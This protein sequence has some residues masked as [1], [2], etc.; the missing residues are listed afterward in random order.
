MDDKNQV[1]LANYQDEINSAYLYEALSK[2]EKNEQLSE[3]YRKMSES[4]I[5]HAQFWKTRLED[6]GIHVEP[7]PDTRSRMLRWIAATFGIQTILPILIGGEKNASDA[8]NDKTDPQL[9]EM[10]G[11]EESHER[12]MRQMVSGTRGG[13]EGGTVAQMEGR[14][15]ASGGNALRAAVLG[16]NDGL[17]SNLSLVMGVAGAE[18]A[19]RSILIT[20]LAGLLAGAASMALGEWLSVQ[21]SR[22]LYQ[23]QIDIERAEIENAPEEEAEELSLIYQAKG[24]SEEQANHLTEKIMADKNTTVDTLAREELGINPEELGG[25]AWE[26]AITSFFLFAVGAIIPVSP[27]IFWTG[28]HAII[29]SLIFS[30]VGLFVIGALIT[31]MT[32]KNFFQSGFRQ[33]VFGLVAAGL[34]F[35]IG[36][37]IGVSIGG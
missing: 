24:L 10:A 13:M 16:A 14:H 1:S 6:A 7:K 2:L 5:K 31:L 12:L 35:G 27:F 23:H 18:L 26:A 3:V 11:E 9:M 4:E 37:L 21:S 33:V 25:S 36:K 15:K 29:L 30:A 28:T 34:T 17:V 32:G 19:G 8:Y 20:G 22:E